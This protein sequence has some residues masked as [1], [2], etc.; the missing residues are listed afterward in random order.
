MDPQ[1]S[2]AIENDFIVQHALVIRRFR[3]MTVRDSVI[4][5]FCCNRILILPTEDAYDCC[6]SNGSDDAD[7]RDIDSESEV[8]EVRNSSDLFLE[9]VPEFMRVKDC[10]VVRKSNDLRPVDHRCGHCAVAT[11]AAIVVIIVV[12]ARWL[13]A[14]II[15]DH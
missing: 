12:A 2:S 6:V 9:L 1:I 11:F 5:S 13:C 14:V 3:Y 4:T 7:D 8:D 15:A 10:P